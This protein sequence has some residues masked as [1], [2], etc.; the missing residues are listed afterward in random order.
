MKGERVRIGS[1]GHRVCVA[2][3]VSAVSGRAATAHVDVGGGD[4]FPV[5]VSLQKGGGLWT[6]FDSF[7]KG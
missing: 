3:L 1:A 7:S 4:C 6:A 5:E 2:A